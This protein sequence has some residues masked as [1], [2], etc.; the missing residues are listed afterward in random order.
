MGTDS[1]RPDDPAGVG[2][3]G[4]QA[5]TSGAKVRFPVPPLLFVG[6]LAAALALHGV[7]PWRLPLPS[8]ARLAG[9]GV[10]AAGAALSGSGA[11]AFRRAGTTVVPH[12]PVSALVTAGPYRL[13]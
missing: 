3:P 1:G 12:Q 10:V 6:P 11:A 13:T 7:R 4:E 2:E 8:G 5:A 9:V